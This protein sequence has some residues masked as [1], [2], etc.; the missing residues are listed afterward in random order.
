[1][2]FSIPLSRKHGPLFRQV[3]KGLRE[4]I[5]SG[6]FSARGRLPSTRDLAEQLGVSRT[7]VLLMTSCS[8]KV[9]QRAGADLE[10]MS[11]QGLAGPLQRGNPAPL[12]CACRALAQRPPILREPSIRRGADTLRSAM[13]LRIGEAILKPFHS[14]CGGASC[15]AMRDRLH[16]ANLIAARR[17]GERWEPRDSNSQM[18]MPFLGD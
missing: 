9:S 14:R 12:G 15:F 16:C 18:L 10:R 7:V 11:P 5:L 17:W 8:P 6:A 13:T 1:M 3:Y 2:E 4:A